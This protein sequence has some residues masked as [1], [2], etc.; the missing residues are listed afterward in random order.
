MSKTRPIALP[1]G[2]V[3]VAWEPSL[4]EAA[5]SDLAARVPPCLRFM[6][7]GWW[8][9]WG[10]TM[11]P[12]DRWRGPLRLAVARDGRGVAQAALPVA[13]QMMLSLPVLSLAGNYKPFRSWLIA[14]DAPGET[15]AGLVDFFAGEAGAKALRL[16]PMKSDMAE[17]RLLLDAFRAAGWRFCRIGQGTEFL[18]DVPATFDAYKAIVGTKKFQRIRYKKNRL[19]REGVVRVER[20]RGAQLE[21][22]RRAIADAAKVE[23][24]SWLGRLGG[25]PNYADPRM[26]SMWQRYFGHEQ[27]S[28]ASSIWILY[29]DDRPISFNATLDS[30][31]CRFLMA[32]AYDE[33]FKGF[34]PGKIVALDSIVSAFDDGIR[35]FNMGQGATGYKAEW[36][37]DRE[38]HLEDWLVLPPTPSGR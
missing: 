37:A 22:W 8:Q 11:L 3:T 10:E 35:T 20:F 15:A 4:D 34:S 26:A 2:D 9:A 14:E 16:G 19:S 24:A 32:L 23:Q 7:H 13:R 33:G 31:D 21:A 38:E 36:G 28:A 6:A 1:A 17:T 18:L 5:W 12:Y 29:L 27:A 30:G 25:D